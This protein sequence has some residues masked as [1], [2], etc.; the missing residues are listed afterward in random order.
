M[1]KELATRRRLTRVESRALTRKRLLQAGQEVFAERGFYGAP[2]EKIGL[3]LRALDQGF[4]LQSYVDPEAVPKYAFVDALEFLSKAFVA[5]SVQQRE[6]S[7]ELLPG[8]LDTS[9]LR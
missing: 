3:L 9:H 2:I 4:D 7:D 1:T 8:G 5:L 6:E